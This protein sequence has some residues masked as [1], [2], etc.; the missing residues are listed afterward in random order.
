MNRFK[1]KILRLEQ[2]PGISQSAWDNFLMLRNQILIYQKFGYDIFQAGENVLQ[3]LP[4]NPGHLL[5]ISGKPPILTLLLAFKGF[6][7]NSIHDDN[8]TISLIIQY[9]NVINERHNAQFLLLQKDQLPFL[10]N[11][12]HN[13]VNFHLLRT[14]PNPRPMVSELHRIIGRKGKIIFKDFNRNGIKLLREIR[15]EYSQIDEPVGVSLFEIAEYFD[16]RDFI[17]TCL[18][19]EFDTTITIDTPI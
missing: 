11:N 5:E 17:V 16:R 4:K 6:K 1:Q 14:M 7:F 2:A 10:N 9:L 19:E 3:L 13:I 15:K 8:D 12:L 18:R